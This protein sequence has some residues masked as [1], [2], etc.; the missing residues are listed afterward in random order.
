MGPSI[1]L[2]AAKKVER[3]HGH[4]EIGFL[5]DTFNKTVEESVF[6]TGVDFDPARI[7]EHFFHFVLGADNQEV[8]HIAGIAGFIGNTA[9]DFGEETIVDTGNGGHCLGGKEDR[10]RIGTVDLDL[11]G[12]SPVARIITKL[13]DAD[14]EAARDRRDDV[15]LGA[16]KKGLRGV[17][18]A[19]P[20]DDR[21]TAC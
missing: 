1:V 13:I 2:L 17:L 12:V 16:D 3:T 15:A 20:A 21:A 11:N 7:G 9:R 10:V 19:D 14:R 6:D 18:L 5:G 8:D 4:G